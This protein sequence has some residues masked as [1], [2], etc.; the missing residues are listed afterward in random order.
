MITEMI[1]NCVLWINA[2]PP[3]GGVS[4]SISP[5]TLLTGVKLDYNCHCKLAFGA[6]A[7]VHGENLPKKSQQART[8]GAI[9]LGPSGNLQGG[10]KIMNLRTGKKLTHR[11][12]T[13]LPMPQEVIDCVNK[14]GEADRQPYI[15]TFYD[16]HGNLVGDSENPNAD[17]T[18]APEEETEENE[19]VTEITGVYQEPPD[20]KQQDLKIPDDNQNDNDINY[21]IK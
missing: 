21:G 5:R 8:L 2:F 12:W 4:A 3:K 14:L 11:R 15:L 18:D 19:P 17:L 10:Y 13:A 7:Q 1:Y 20:D 16:R 9:C 6:Y